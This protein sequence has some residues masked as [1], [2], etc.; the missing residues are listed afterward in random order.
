[1][2]A[3][4]LHRL[5]L[6]G[7]LLGGCERR[8]TTP[9]ATKRAS[10]QDSYRQPARLVAALDIKA[11]DWVAEIGAGGGYLTPRL[12]AAVGT[13]GRVVATDID[14]EALAALRR[15]TAG[16]PQVTVRQ[17]RADAPG[18]GGDTFDLILLAHVDHLLPNRADYLRALRPSLQPGGRIVIDNGER[19][20]EA[21]RA[22]AQEAGF[23]V[24][25]IAVERP[26]QFLL[27]LRQ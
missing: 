6:V 20:R 3:S 27:Q 4:R 14:G 23:R 5:L 22:A 2:T 18:L 24:E 21:V 15:R 10:A 16:L 1:M 25:E 17:V 13:S 12:A 8:T 26:A 19:H 9:Q 11:G 7:L